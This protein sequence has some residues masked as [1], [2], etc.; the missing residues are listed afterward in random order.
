MLLRLKVKNFL[1]FYHEVTFDMFPNPKRTTLADHVYTDM[2]VPLLKQAALYG[3]NASGK[4][5]LLKAVSFIEK[6]A[7]D[8]NFLKGSVGIDQLKFALI[9]ENNLPIAISTEFVIENQYFIYEIEISETAVEKEALYQS[10]LNKKNNELI[11]KRS[12]NEILNKGKQINKELKKAIDQLIMDNPLSSIFSLNK[13]FP[14]IKDERS[15]LAHKWF[16]ENLDTLFLSRK[17]PKLIYYL[18]ADNHLLKFA[19]KIITSIDVG[20]QNIEIEQKKISELSKDKNSSFYRDVMSFYSQ[21]LEKD[22]SDGIS[23][24]LGDKISFS[25]DKEEGETIVRRALFKQL[26]LNKYIGS[27]RLDQQ[28]DGTAKLL[29][30]IPAIYDIIRKPC[31]YFIDEIEHSVHPTLI[32]KLLQFLANTPTKGQLIYTTHQTKLMDQKE[33]LRPDEIWITEKHEG[34]SVLYSV[35]EFKEHN[36]MDLEKGYLDGRFGGI[37]DIDQLGF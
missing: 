34:N 21:E 2:E 24:E 14:I 22:S 17:I 8:E 33:L 30:L 1:S 37:P 11:F 7:T 12:R 3:A 16:T 28:S 4:S 25:I 9:E 13:K 32:Y 35:N 15:K 23:V 5:N 36:T 31:V 10:G 26:G 6:F 20:V 18:A 27:L 19:S 29:D